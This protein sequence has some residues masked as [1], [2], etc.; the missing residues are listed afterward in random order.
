MRGTVTDLVTPYPIGAYLPAVYQEDSFVQRFTSGL[1]DVLAPAIAVL[2]SLEA[3]AD[4]D[5]APVDFLPWLAGW[6]GI[7]VE[8]TL[9]EAARRARVKHAAESF[10]VRG[11]YEGL[12]DALR[13]LTGAWVEVVDSGGVHC[14]DRAGG[15]GPID[16]EPAV[17]V[18]LPRALAAQREAVEALVAGAVPAHV[19][20]AVE[21]LEHDHVS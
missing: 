3:Y 7:T 19:H 6:L 5:T 10:V 20:R 8:E 15:C 1:D 14:S 16:A 13:T 2:D 18:R 12:R 9:P 4:P 21:L 11:T 17:I